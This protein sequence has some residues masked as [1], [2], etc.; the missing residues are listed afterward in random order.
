M[1]R[2]AASNG[3]YVSLADRAY[4]RL[5][6]E[7]TTGKLSPGAVLDRRSIAERLS[8]STIPV[9]EAIRR[10]EKDGLIESRARWPARVKV[11][12]AESIRG[13]YDVREALAAQAARLC[14]AHA[15]DDELDDLEGIAREAHRLLADPQAAADEGGREHMRFHERLAELT[16]CPTLIELLEMINRRVLMRR[17]W[18]RASLHSSRPP[19]WHARI[20]AAIRSRDALKADEAARARRPQARPRE[21][22]K[23]VPPIGWGRDVLCPHLPRHKPTRLPISAIGSFARRHPMSTMR[24]SGRQ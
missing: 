19:D 6:S 3:S 15:T 21:G 23:G 10:L 16:R 20:V 1:G 4:E 22:E 11:H 14:A 2:K 12:D 17:N 13:E 24:S 5:L 9:L 8:M 18:T 7:I